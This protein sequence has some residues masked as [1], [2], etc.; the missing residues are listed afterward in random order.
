MKRTYSIVID[1]KVL[2]PRKGERGPL[3]HPLP[4]MLSKLEV[5]QSFA[6][7]KTGSGI[8]WN[9]LRSIASKEGR[10]KGKRYPTRMVTEGGK[11][12]LRFWRTA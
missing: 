4:F 6:W 9:L 11:K 5:G 8:N 2:L 3:V 7:P 10:R 1:D 12:K